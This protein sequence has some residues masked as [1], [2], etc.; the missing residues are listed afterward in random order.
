MAG[1]TTKTIDGH[2]KLVVAAGNH[3]AICLRPDV[4]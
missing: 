4:R 1:R 2:T 3:A